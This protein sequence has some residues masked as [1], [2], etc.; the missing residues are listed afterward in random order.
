MSVQR[1]PKQV[2]EAIIGNLQ[3]VQAAQEA[4]SRLAVEEME[5]DVYCQSAGVAIAYE[6]AIT[7]IRTEAQHILEEPS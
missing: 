3:M 6:E 2:I 4:K 5:W 7:L 1:T